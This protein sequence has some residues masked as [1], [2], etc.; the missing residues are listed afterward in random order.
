MGGCLQR[1]LAAKTEHL[2]ILMSSAKE[3]GKLVHVHVDQFNSDEERETEQ[4]ARK[5]IEH[6][7]QGKVSAIH[8]ISLAAHP[9]KVPPRG[10]R[11]LPRSRYEYYFLPHGL[12]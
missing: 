3:H 11:T 4:L 9:E 8:C 10:V 2:D 6:G 12:D 7:M 1:I 5:T